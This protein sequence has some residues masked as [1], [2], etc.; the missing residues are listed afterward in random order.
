LFFRVTWWC[1]FWTKDP[2]HIRN[3]DS[4][5]FESSSADMPMPS[6]WPD[7]FSFGAA[8]GIAQLVV[9]KPKDG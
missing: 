9:V 8:F 3:D 7:A 1:A 6:G 2:K 5:M 4:A